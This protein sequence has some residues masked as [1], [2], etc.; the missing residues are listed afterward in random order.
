M[1]FPLLPPQWR[2]EFSEWGNG[3]KK[4]IVLKLVLTCLL[5]LMA[6]SAS[7]T[8][9]K[10]V[11]FGSAGASYTDTGRVQTFIGFPLAGRTYPGVGQTGV[12]FSYWDL[13]SRT[14]VVSAVGDDLPPVHNELFRNFPNPFNPSTQIR[15]SVAQEAAVRVE[16]Y[17]LMGRKVDSLVDE[18][19][20]AGIYTVTYQPRNLASGA[21]VILMRVGSYRATQ[22]MMLVK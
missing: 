14:L 15:Y 2:T 17:D 20:P 16:V 22:S 1:V 8:E 10:L 7:A 4:S 13:L 5:V 21:Y 3:V 19:K 18:V 11:T 9:V 6:A 12:K